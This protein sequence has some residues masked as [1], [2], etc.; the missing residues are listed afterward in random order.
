MKKAFAFGKEITGAFGDIGVFLPLAIALIKGCGISHV[1]L[2]G[3]AGAAA[4]FGGLFYGI[5][6]PVQPLKAMAAICLSLSLPPSVISSAALWMGALMIFLSLFKNIPSFLSRAF[7]LPVV[8]GLQL[9]LGLLLVKAGLS[10]ILGTQK[11]STASALMLPSEFNFLYPFFV[12]V[13]PQIP[14]TLGNA[15]VATTDTAKRYYGERAEKIT[16]KNLLRET[17]LWNLAAGVFGGFPVCRGSGGVTAH[18]L[19]GARTA[20]AP[21]ILGLFFLTCAS[22]HVQTLYGILTI[23][24]SWF[25]GMC[26]VYIGVCHALLVKDVPLHRFAP[27]ALMSFTGF[28]TG[29]LTYAIFAGWIYLTLER[30]V[31]YA[32][33]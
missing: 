5:P 11:A 3:V 25:L 27:V 4:I 30:K 7:P 16:E 18:Y 14:L 15:V 21:I 1:S 12:L 26:V 9:G 29:N 24:P 20:A 31:V 23:I 13:L 2:F 28:F 8:R 19:F 17:G 6:V 22:L 10:L 32:Y 33:R